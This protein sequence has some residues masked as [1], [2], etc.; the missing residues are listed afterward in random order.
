MPDVK[1]PLPALVESLTAARTAAEQ[2]YEQGA[3]MKIP[4]LLESFAGALKTHNEIN[5]ILGK[6]IERVKIQTY[7]KSGGRF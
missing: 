4:V 1:H 6:T 3:W 2:L 5:Q 7:A